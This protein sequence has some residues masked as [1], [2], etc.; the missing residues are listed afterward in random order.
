MSGRKHPDY[1]T[2]GPGGA[3]M[4]QPTIRHPAFCGC[5]RCAKL[6][7]A[8]RAKPHAYRIYRASK[9]PTDRILSGLYARQVKEEEEAKLHRAPWV[10]RPNEVTFSQL[11]D[12][13]LD[14]HGAAIRDVERAKAAIELHL[15]PFFGIYRAADL[16]ALLVIKYQAQRAAAGAAPATVNREWNVLRAVMSFAAKHELIAQNPIKKGTVKPLA[17]P[18][19]KSEF[20][21]PAEWRAFI[22]N[23]GPKMAPLFRGLFYT[24]ARLG[25]LLTLTWAHVD[26]KR[27]VVR[28][29][30]GK[31]Q[32]EK[33]LPI[34]DALRLELAA[35]TPGIGAALVYTIDG[36]AVYQEEVR[37][38]FD[39]ALAAAGIRKHLTPHSIRHT[40]GSWLTIA[41]VSEAQ[42]AEVL[43]HRRKSTTAGYSHLRRVDLMP[44]MATLERIEREGFSPAESVAESAE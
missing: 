3:L 12:A 8:E 29:S 16:K 24:A 20:F 41:G 19:P 34:A 43:G 32:R 31:T 7:D 5:D 44:V 10:T 39:D 28:I 18:E 17:A 36:R 9:H 27:R 15:R 6:A 1:V 13:Y 30:Q 26:Q 14:V 38:A 25:E 22:A 40:V 37:R 11:C 23:A 21:E 2:T 35:L 33:V 42:V 4:I